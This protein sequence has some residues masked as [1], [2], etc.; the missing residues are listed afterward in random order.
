MALGEDGGTH[1]RIR[2]LSEK[3]GPATRA[4]GL[5]REGFVVVVAGISTSDG[6]TRI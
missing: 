4:R 1:D 3:G 5:E 2:L 6:L